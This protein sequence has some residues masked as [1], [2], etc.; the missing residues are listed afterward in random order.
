VQAI[1]RTSYNWQTYFDENRK[2]GQISEEKIAEAGIINNQCWEN[3][4]NKTHNI[5]S[6]PVADICVVIISIKEI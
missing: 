4:Y 6:F 3:P 1:R 5:N 2:H